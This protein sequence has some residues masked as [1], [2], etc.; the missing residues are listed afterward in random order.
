MSSTTTFLA[1]FNLD[2]PI[3]LMCCQ[4]PRS[5]REGLVVTTLTTLS[6]LVAGEGEKRCDGGSSGILGVLSSS[7]FLGILGFLNINSALLTHAQSRLELLVEGSTVLKERNSNK[8][9]QKDFLDVFHEVSNVIFVK[10]LREVFEHFIFYNSSFIRQ[11]VNMRSSNLPS[12]KRKKIQMAWNN[13]Y[14]SRI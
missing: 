13:P 6:V 5:V 3:G 8:N 14:Q 11:Y 12:M 1:E 2:R 4:T 9:N 7:V 10:G